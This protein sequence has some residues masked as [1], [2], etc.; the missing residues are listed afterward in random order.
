MGT[1]SLI[2][3]SSSDDTAHPA[4]SEAEY[5]R[6]DRR[7]DMVLDQTFPASD[8]IP[9]IHDVAPRAPIP[10]RGGRQAVDDRLQAAN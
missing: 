4:A 3:L 8:P 6:A 9:W 5:A 7:L 10:H 1:S 2:C